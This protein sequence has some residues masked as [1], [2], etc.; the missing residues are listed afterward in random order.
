VLSSSRVRSL[1]WRLGRKL[2]QYARLEGAN[3][4][5][6]N[7]EYWLLDAVVARAP[8]E[9]ELTLLDVGAHRGQWTHE[10]LDCLSR[11]G[12][13]GQ[14]HAFE[15]TPST[16][17]FLEQR[18]AA[19]PRVRLQ[20]FALSDRPG[21]AA[22]YVVGE[23]VGINSLVDMQVGAPTPVDVT[24]VDAYLSQHRIDRIAFLKSDTEGNDLGVLRGGAGA[25]AEG[26]IDAWQ[27][28]YNSRWIYAR[29]FLR[30]VFELIMGKPYVLGKLHG[31]GV[32]LFDAWHPELE[33]YFETNFVLLR[34]G[35]ALERLG[36]RSRFDA[37]N[38]P[39][40][41][42]R[43]GNAPGLSGGHGADAADRPGSSLAL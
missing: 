27:F 18:F 10:A 3:D 34:A 25:L 15:P 42:S 2:Y 26:R 40:R 17:R 35:T 33:R 30:D 31:G 13:T 19:E 6:S 1:I 32:E 43:A 24:T 23:L 41:V 14:V 11:H 21:M 9:A 39:M 38:A 4:P 36:R 5:H 12:R 8:R 7:G 37:S 20:P 29:A 28:E 16:Q 22:L